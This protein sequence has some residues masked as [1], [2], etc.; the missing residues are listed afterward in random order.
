MSANYSK[1]FFRFAIKICHFFKNAVTA[2]IFPYPRV[3][4]SPTSFNSWRNA[5]QFTWLRRSLAL[6]LFLSM[7]DVS[8]WFL[9]YAFLAI[10][11]RLI[12]HMVS[13]KILDTLLNCKLHSSTFELAHMFQPDNIRLESVEKGRISLS[14]YY[15]HVLN[16]CTK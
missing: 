2:F 14:G 8:S 10:G 9:W 4:D 16:S 5:S 3:S 15:F 11:Y 7:L 12:G 6:D 1:L 13:P